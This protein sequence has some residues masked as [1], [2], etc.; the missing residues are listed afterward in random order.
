MSQ[1]KRKKRKKRRVLLGAVTGIVILILAIAFFVFFR[2]EEP[3]DNHFDDNSADINTEKMDDQQASIMEEQES[4][5]EFTMGDNLKAAIIQLALTYDHFD[6]DSVDSQ[7][8]K[9]TFVAKFI[10]NSRLSFDYLETISEQNNGQIN[11]D[12]LNYI[13][14][15]LTGIE[16][17]FSSY[18]GG[19]VD[20]YDGASPL[21]YG[22]ISGYDYENTDNGVIV[23]ADFEVGF[24]GTDSTQKRKITAELVKNPQSCFDGYSVVSVSSEVMD[25]GAGQEENPTGEYEYSSDYGAGK[26]IIQKT[27]DGYDISDYESEDSYRFLA[28][29]SNIETIENNRIYIKYPEQVFSDGAADF[30][31]YILEYSADGINVYYRKSPQGEEQFLYHATKKSDN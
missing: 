26:L 31:Y 27:S 28:D 4:P 14:Y 23:T 19:S 9:E 24:D 12:E 21:N 8:W 15:S 11:G 16:V 6:K 18:A 2:T 17:D 5:L 13:Q 25:S 22:S 3:A 7:D 20:R 30:C 10:Q 1:H 29:S